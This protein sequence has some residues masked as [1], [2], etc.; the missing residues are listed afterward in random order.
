M[1]S[2][3]VRKD[4]FGNTKKENNPEPVRNVAPSF[5]NYNEPPKKSSGANLPPTK[6][7]VNKEYE[8]N[9]FNNQ[10]QM[11]NQR[12]FNNQNA[13]NQN[14]DSEKILE[15]YENIKWLNSSKGYIRPTTER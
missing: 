4:P 14:N 11:N 2:G 5:N 10:N 7:N 12:A 15:E 8:G 9:Q 1:D 13:Q 3:N 6:S